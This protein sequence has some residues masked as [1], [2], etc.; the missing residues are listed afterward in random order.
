VIEESP[1]FF[2]RLFAQLTV[3]ILGVGS[4]SN[5]FEPIFTCNQRTST[6]GDT[7]FSCGNDNLTQFSMSVT[8][9][10]WL[11]GLLDTPQTSEASFQ[12]T[13]NSAFTFSQ[14]TTNI[15][16]NSITNASTI[17]G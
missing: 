8:T 7:I 11:S 17:N 15:T 3:T 9:Y 6:N 1:R 2:C 13:V 5:Q 4:F 14:L 16:S 10:A 12:A